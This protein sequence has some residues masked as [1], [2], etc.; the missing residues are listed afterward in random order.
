MSKTAIIALASPRPAISLEDG[1]ER[2]ER[3]V[4]AAA[5]QKA[6]VV[7]FPE[8]IFPGCAARTFP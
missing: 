4:V 1:L 7:C 6:E 2:V 8:P 3:L 5:E